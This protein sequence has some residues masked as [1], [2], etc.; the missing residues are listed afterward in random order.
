MS[1]QVL[2]K[3]K[4]QKRLAKCQSKFQLKANKACQVSK[5]VL[6]KLKA[7]KACKVSKQVSPKLKAKVGTKFA[8][9]HIPSP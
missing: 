3:L 1:K 5:Q 2:Q 8:S 7:N 9:R 4:A 6:Q